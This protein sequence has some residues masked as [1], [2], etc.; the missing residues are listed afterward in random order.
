MDGWYVAELRGV[1]DEENGLNVYALL[2]NLNEDT[3]IMYAAGNVDSEEPNTFFGAGLGALAVNEYPMSTLDLEMGGVGIYNTFDDKL[4]AAQV[5]YNDI[6]NWNEDEGVWEKIGN[7]L[8]ITML[9]SK[10]DQFQRWH[11][12]SSFI[13]N[14]GELI[15]PEA[16]ASEVNSFLWHPSDDGSHPFSSY[17]LL[18]DSITTYDGAA[19]HGAAGGYGEDGFL[20]GGGRALYVAPDGEDGYDAGIMFIREIGG[21]YSQTSNIFAY[22]EIV[23][24]MPLIYGTEFGPEDLYP[25]GA[26]V[27]DSWDSGNYV[28]PIPGGGLLSGPLDDHLNMYFNGQDWGIWDSEYH[29]QYT[30]FGGSEWFALGT[31]DFINDT[32]EGSLYYITHGEL[33]GESSMQFETIGFSLAWDTE[34]EMGV[35]TFY[36]GTTMGMCNSHFHGIGLGTYFNDT[37]FGDF[38]TPFSTDVFDS[39]VLMFAQSPPPTPPEWFGGYLN[40]GALDGYI[41]A[42]WVYGSEI[43]FA[44]TE[45]YLR[46]GLIALWLRGYYYM[47]PEGEYDEW[48]LP[49][50]GYGFPE[51]VPDPE[52]GPNIWTGDKDLVWLGSIRG[53]SWQDGALHGTCKGFW[54][55]KHEDEGVWVSA[56]FFGGSGGEGELVGGAVGNYIDGEDFEWNAMAV[57]EW[58]EVTELF[59]ESIFNAVNDFVTDAPIVEIYNY[60]GLAGAGAF[61]GPG[62]AMGTINLNMDINFLTNAGGDRI[63]NAII[64]GGFDLGGASVVNGWNASFV[65]GDNH[66][67]FAG[68]IWDDATNSWHANVSGV[69]ESHLISGGSQAAGVFDSEDGTMLG[70]GTGGWTNAD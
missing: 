28:N 35:R 21:L 61:L 36:S 9:A 27:E 45:D 49:I 51:M 53:T 19:F 70:I 1:D 14:I 16:E 8:S 34:E 23:E 66:I 6:S 29:F 30:P 25:G 20:Y 24:T 31:G 11:G 54:Y 39:R 13:S 17:D 3:G 47:P 62:G 58:V 56:G 67:D 26:I 7:A 64:E 63:W 18:H 32:F 48:F 42:N 43:G 33:Y 37:F 68:D 65:D 55:T 38:V 15:F 46:H 4:F 59:D 5:H 12:F 44:P 41:G 57:A 10:F 52:R 40:D 50:G 2:R 22:Q 60:Q 69:W